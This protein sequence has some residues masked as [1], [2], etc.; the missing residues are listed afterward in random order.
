MAHTSPFDA[1]PV[2]P[3]D[4]IFGVLQ[5]FKADPSPKKVNLSVGAY[6]TDEGQPY[7]LKAVRQA[8]QLLVADASLN[9]EYLPIEGLPEFLQHAAKL[10]FG[11]NHPVLTEKRLAIAQSISGT[12]ALSIG[13]DFIAHFFPKGTVVYLSDPTWG[14]HNKIFQFAGI[15]VRTYAYFDNATNGLDFNGMKHD[16]E[17]APEGSVILL[18]ACAHN[19]TGVDPTI[20]QWKELASL[21]QT[22]N[23]FPLFDCAYQGFATG[24]FDSDAQSF[25]IFAE[26]GLQFLLT[27][28]FAKNMGL[29][30]ERVG[31]ISAVCSSEKA[32]SAVLSQFKSLIRANYSNPPRNGAYIAHKV[33]STPQLYQVWIEEVKMM[34]ERIKE[35]RHLLYNELK[36]LN[37]PGK[38][39]HI[40]TQ[41]GMF[42]YTGLS[43]AQ[44]AI[45]QSEY[46]IYM[47]GQGRA[48]MAGFTH[49][50][51]EYVAKAIDDVVRRKSSNL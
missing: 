51:V 34:S 1:T 38:W 20:D 2:A 13:A 50:N 22:R 42:S 40:V 19:P 43:V 28:S 35:M 45:L 4:I 39:E 8:E 15:P 37:T 33:L 41:I 30:A 26:R 11:A 10:L 31:T 5:Q 17:Q 32:A 9:K 44:C 25:R 18:H 14:N 49:G 29:Y 12:G 48:S 21:F 36:R 23:L 3:P 24:D 46:H 7:V 47:I 6:R 16:L 27:Q